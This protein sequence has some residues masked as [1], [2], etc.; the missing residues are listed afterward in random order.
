MTRSKIVMLYSLVVSI[1]F[2]LSLA[3]Y[4]ALAS[5]VDG[6]LITVASLLTI[7][8]FP[9]ARNISDK[10]VT[11]EMKVLMTK[12]FAV[13]LVVISMMVIY[14]LVYYY[15]VALPDYV[16]PTSWQNTVNRASDSVGSLCGFI[17]LFLKWV[18]E[19]DATSYFFMV[20][21][22]QQD[23][24][25]FAPLIWIIY[26]VK[27]ALVFAALARLQA[28]CIAFSVKFYKVDQET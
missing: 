2:T 6:V 20:T 28:E 12:R 18:Q 17:N 24:S 7:F 10:H 22:S 15:E 11:E 8:F 23:R 27:Q 19:L 14:T 16:D 9:W 4:I 5:G 26:F 13:L 3:S 25:N 21:V 1:T